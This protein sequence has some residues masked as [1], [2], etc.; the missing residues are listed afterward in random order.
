MPGKNVVR[1]MLGLFLVAVFGLAGCGGGGGGGAAVDLPSAGSSATINSSGAIVQL[2]DGASATVSGG[3]APNNAQTS[4]SKLAQPQVSLNQA[5]AVSS[6]YQMSIPIDSNSFNSVQN[7]TIDNAITF[8]IPMPTN[9]ISKALSKITSLATGSSDETYYVSEVT[10]TY[11]NVTTSVYG[12]YV[13]SNGVATVSL[14]KQT[15]ASLLGGNNAT[16]KKANN[17]LTDSLN[18]V[19]TAKIIDVKNKFTAPNQALYKVSSPTVFEEVVSAEDTGGKIP[20]VL[21]HG[22]QRLGTDM[23]DIKPEQDD[24]KNFINYFYSDSDLTAKFVLYTYRYDSKKDIDTN[25]SNLATTINN[26]FPNAPKV[27][28]TAHSMGGLVSHSYIQNHGGN[29][30]VLKLI[31]LGT[32]YH[33]SPVIQAVNGNTVA[34]VLDQLLNPTSLAIF[35][36]ENIFLCLASPGTL[37]LRWDNF[38][39]N[40][41]ILNENTYLKKLN[42]TMKN[43]DLYAAFAGSMRD[44]NHGK[45]DAT[46][47]L[48]S[49]LGYGYSSTDARKGND[50]VV[51]V[52]SAFNNGHPGGFLEIGPEDNYDHGQ[53]VD[54]RTGNNSDPIFALI[55]EQLLADATY[56]ISG[57]ITSGGAPLADVTVTLTGS[58]STSTRTDLNGHYSF[59]SQPNGNYTLSASKTDYTL[60]ANQSVTVS[61]APS[62]GNNFTATEKTTTYS[63][64]GRVSAAN[65][66]ALS[67]VTV[68]LTGSGPVSTLTDSSGFYVF[69]GA[70]NGNYTLSASKTGYTL[71]ANQTVTVSSANITGK[72]FTATVIAPSTYTISGKVTLDGVALSNVLMTITGSS[73]TSPTNTSGNYS[74][75]GVASGTYIITPSLSGYA[76]TPASRTV[77]INGGN[78]ASQDFTAT[79]TGFIQATW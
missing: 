39:N 35:T 72:N 48:N 2:P 69:S 1:V 8:Q 66:D 65:G 77:T 44:I 28:I 50:G 79:N 53:M 9:T 70:Q 40:P 21:I 17:A 33:G 47:P 23:N 71:S 25:G 30:K 57:Q 5:T 55:K 73:L 54:G 52:V 62:S 16:A 56:T 29:S 49:L 59:A 10:I 46:Y 11:N 20:L 38:D 12:S 19:I 68:T 32:P 64:S 76:F 34:G 37:D 26:Y 67:G 51:P 78:P 42:S 27:A 13:T 7:S 45:Y 4:L 74:F 60:S 31:T 41:R 63:I 24:W 43:A 14:P 22:W 36:A 75:T 18:A 58:T 3:V 15:L 6:S 61:N